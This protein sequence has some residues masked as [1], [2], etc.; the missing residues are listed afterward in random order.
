MPWQGSGETATKGLQK[1][2]CV[3]RGR[4]TLTAKP[5][6]GG[7]EGRDF[8]YSGLAEVKLENP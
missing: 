5:Y 7:G 8:S 6:G 4:A 1:S 3:N 2:D